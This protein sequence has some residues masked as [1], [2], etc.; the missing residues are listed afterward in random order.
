MLALYDNNFRILYY[1]AR[2]LLRKYDHLN[3]VVS[4]YHPHIICIVE[5]W[6][7]KDIFDIELL[8]R[9]K[10]RNREEESLRGL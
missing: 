10:R 6:L 2:S 9:K 4:L 3:I 1:N 5:S 8:S 7:C